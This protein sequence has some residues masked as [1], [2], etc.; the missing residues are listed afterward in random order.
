MDCF[1]V[2]NQYIIMW[3]RFLIVKKK[4]NCSTKDKSKNKSTAF[5]LLICWWYVLFDLYTIAVQCVR[6][7]CVLSIICIR[8]FTF[9]NEIHK[10]IINRCSFYFLIALELEN[11]LSIWKNPAVEWK[12]R[13]FEKISWEQ[14]Y[15]HGLPSKVFKIINIKIVCNNIFRIF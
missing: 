4:K 10:W 3:I 14:S 5:N 15:S 13:T 8:T 9:I 2:I 7:L 11:V 1:H 12:I 6:K